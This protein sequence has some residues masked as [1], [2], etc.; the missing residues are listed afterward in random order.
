MRGG[1]GLDGEWRIGGE[2]WR[3]VFKCFVCW[4]I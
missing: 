3:I 2:G 4:V 1:N